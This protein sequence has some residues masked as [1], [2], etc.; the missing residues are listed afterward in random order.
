MELDYPRTIL[1]LGLFWSQDY[2]RIESSYNWDNVGFEN[3]LAGIV[4]EPELS[5]N[6]FP[7][8]GIDTNCTGTDL[9]S[10]WN[11]TGTVIVLG[12]ELF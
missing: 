4:L 8:I 10:S 12:P 9:Y 6:D 1:S 7:V 5:H 11:Y 3:F 2:L